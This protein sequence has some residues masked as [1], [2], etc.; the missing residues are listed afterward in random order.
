LEDVLPPLMDNERG[1]LD[2]FE[3]GAGDDDDENCVEAV[4]DAPCDC[5]GELAL[6]MSTQASDCARECLG[7]SEFLSAKSI[8]DSCKALPPYKLGHGNENG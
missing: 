7:L 3:F 1:F 2:P 8:S 6:G 4:G 5:C